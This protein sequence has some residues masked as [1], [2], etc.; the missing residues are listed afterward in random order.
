TKK[1][2]P[3]KA[4]RGKGLNVLLEVALSEAAQLIQNEAEY[5]HISQAS[6]SG[7]GTDFESGVPNEQQRKKSGA[8][9]RTGTKS[10]VLDA[11]KY[12]SESDKE[13]WGDSGEKEDDDE[14]DTEDD[15]G[16]DN[17]DDSD[18]NNDDGEDDD[19][20][21]DDNDGNDDDDDS[22]YERTKSYRDENPNLSQFDKEHEEEEEENVDEFTDK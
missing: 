16:N 8:D 22:D 11:P 6:G 15:K 4:D 19:D 21:D 14:D 20:G 7:D 13:S 3:V 10:G 17:D 2:A 1:K 18:R 9:E 5:F 12:D